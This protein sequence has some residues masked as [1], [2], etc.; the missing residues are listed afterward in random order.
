MRPTYLSNIVFIAKQW[1]AP[2]FPEDQH[3]GAGGRLG[4][5]LRRPDRHHVC[6][7]SSVGIGILAHENANTLLAYIFILKIFAFEFKTRKMMIAFFG[8]KIIYS[9]ILRWVT[10]S[11][12]L[13][14]FPFWLQSLAFFSP[15]KMPF[16]RQLDLI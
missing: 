9:I 1:C 13:L 15:Q 10:C 16:I 2:S 12:S 3:G 8:H 5:S 4:G 11:P 14:H 7:W 6:V